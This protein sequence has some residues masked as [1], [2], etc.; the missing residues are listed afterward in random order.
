LIALPRESRDQL[1]ITKTG[2]VG[3]DP[4]AHNHWTTPP[5]AWFDEKADF[6][7]GSRASA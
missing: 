1:L 3:H 7:T 2:E 6:C 4:F 5:E